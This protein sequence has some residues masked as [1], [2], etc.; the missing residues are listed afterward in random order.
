M[1]NQFTV[2]KSE[3]GTRIVKFDKGLTAITKMKLM[4]ELLEVEPDYE[5]VFYFGL[6]LCDELCELTT[7]Q[8][9]LITGFSVNPVTNSLVLTGDKSPYDFPIATEKARQIR[10]EVKKRGLPLW[11]L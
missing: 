10:K 9:A 2:S 7:A 1:K 4:I 5:D 8:L 11:P 6:Y 3:F